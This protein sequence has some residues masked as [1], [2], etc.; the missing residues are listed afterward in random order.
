VPKTFATPEAAIGAPGSL[1]IKPIDA[2]SGKGVQVLHEPTRDAIKDALS[3]AS[4]ASSRGGAVIE[5]FVR[6]QL[7]S[8]SAF[9]EAG[10]VQIAFN[11]VEF[12]SVNPFVVDTSYVVV[13]RPFESELKADVE[14]LAAALD[15]SQGLMHLQYIASETQYWLIEPTR[16][17]PG[18][19]YSEL[20][21]RS[22][23]YPYAEAYISAFV[24]SG[25]PKPAQLRPAYTVRH[26]LAADR[27]GVLDHV[28]FLNRAR[29]AGWYPLASSGALLSPSPGGRVAVAFFNATSASERSSLVEGLIAGKM[30]KIHF[31]DESD[32][33]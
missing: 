1:V 28:Q 5:E 26:T 10:K 23:G 7:H 4:C 29:P 32:G 19:L 25:L 31:R 8:Y 21:Q 14:A 15:I 12:G 33:L 27:E 16:R 2:Y 24:G 22:T 9:L 20:I 11:V 18:D 13:E 3:V 30:L 17:C 6:G